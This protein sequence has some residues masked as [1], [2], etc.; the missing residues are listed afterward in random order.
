MK[1]KYLWKKFK[2]NINIIDKND[3]SYNIFE[4]IYQEYSLI[5]EHYMM[6]NKFENDSLFKKI[7]IIILLF[8]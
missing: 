6:F 3:K 7:E 2:K 8:K 4:D 5:D 1:K